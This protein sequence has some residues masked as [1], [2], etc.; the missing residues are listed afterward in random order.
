VIIIYESFG[1]LADLVVDG[2]KLPHMMSDHTV[3]ECL[4]WQKGVK[5]FARWLDDAG[6]KVITKE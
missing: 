3:E 4:G 5:E 2:E 1:E 6:Y